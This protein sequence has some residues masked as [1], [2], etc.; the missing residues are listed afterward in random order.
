MYKMEFFTDSYE[1]AYS[2]MPSEMQHSQSA[3]NRTSKMSIDPNNRSF[4][5][6]NKNKGVE[7]PKQTQ[8]VVEE[9]TGATRSLKTIGELMAYLN[10]LRK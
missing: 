7:L 2:G 9:Y 3:D 10:T 4:Q 6:D 8:G 1:S 5:V